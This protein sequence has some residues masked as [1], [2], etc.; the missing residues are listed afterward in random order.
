[1]RKTAKVADNDR[2]VAI[3]LQDHFA[4]SIAA[5]ELIERSAR[6]NAANELGSFLTNLHEEI[7]ADQQTLLDVMGALAVEPSRFKNGLGWAVEKAGRLK[8]NGRLLRYSPLSRLYELETLEAGIVGKRSLWTNLQ[9][10]DDPR[11]GGVDL[12]RLVE[13]AEAQRARVEE[14]RRRAAAALGAR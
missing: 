11:L 9:V 7:R 14:W 4:G 1:L 13:R 12:P 3:Y 6:S 10:L 5:I 2:L 8:L